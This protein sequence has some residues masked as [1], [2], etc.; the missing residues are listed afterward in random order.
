MKQDNYYFVLGVSP[1]SS[2]VEIKKAYRRLALQ[3]HPDV[4][5]AYVDTDNESA[6]FNLIH[7]AYKTL[8]DHKSKIEHD[9]ALARKY[10][11][12]YFTK[13]YVGNEGLVQLLTELNTRLNST[14]KNNINFDYLYLSLSIYLQDASNY[15]FLITEKDQLLEKSVVNLLLET[16][17]YLPYKETLA[18]NR[19][20]LSVLRNDENKK[21]WIEFLKKRKWM[22][23]VSKYTVWF[24]LLF[25]LIVGFLIMT[26]TK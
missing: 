2:L 24:V 6:H 20:A 22:D 18:L 7:L 26:G 12:Q 9:R 23:R 16:C 3:F 25:S 5:H 8:S 4:Q 13:Q 21:T 15:N 10:G 19:Q 17:A 14:N 11:K 1:A